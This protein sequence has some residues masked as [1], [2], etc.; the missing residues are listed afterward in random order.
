[1]RLHVVHVQVRRAAAQMDHDDR[2]LPWLARRGRFGPQAEHVT[3]GQPAEGQG[4]DAEEAATRDAVAAGGRTRVVDRQ[5]ETFLDDDAMTM[6]RTAGE[7]GPRFARLLV[8]GGWRAPN[9]SGHQTA[10][11]AP[12]SSPCVVPRDNCRK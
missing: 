12:A 1:R 10:P 8:P 6:V 3:Q 4:P 7:R 2:L 11:V 5:H 9:A